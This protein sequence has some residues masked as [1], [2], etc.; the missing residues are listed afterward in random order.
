MGLEPGKQ[1]FQEAMQLAGP[2]QGDGECIMWIVW[3]KPLRGS[4]PKSREKNLIFVPNDFKISMSFK[5]MLLS[6]C[7]QQKG[8]CMLL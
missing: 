8:Y 2:S 4:E 7:Q 6:F 3:M 1:D 5:Q